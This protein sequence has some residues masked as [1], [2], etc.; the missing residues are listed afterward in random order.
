MDNKNMQGILFQRVVT[1][2]IKPTSRGTEVIHFTIPLGF[3]S[4]IVVA[5]VPGE[6]EV[7]AP[8]YLKFKGPDD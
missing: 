6:G 2:K 7:E 5:N 1:G 4:I 8:V 3:M